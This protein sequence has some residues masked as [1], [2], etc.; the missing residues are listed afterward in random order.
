MGHH[1]NQSLLQSQINFQEIFGLYFS[2]LNRL[3][4]NETHLDNQ[5]VKAYHQ[6]Q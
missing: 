3:N 6:G 2:V 1:Y 5:C 4:L